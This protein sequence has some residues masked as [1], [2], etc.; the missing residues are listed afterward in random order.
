MAVFP[1]ELFEAI[2]DAVEDDKTLHACALVARSFTYPAQRNHFRALTLYSHLSRRS[3]ERRQYQT[4]TSAGELFQQPAS[5]HLALHVRELTVQLPFHPDETNAI[6]VVLDSTKN[7]VRLVA[8]AGSMRW[9]ALPAPARDALLCAIRRPTLQRLH[10]LSMTRIPSGVIAEAL[11]VPVVS[12]YSI[13]MD[14]AEEQADYDAAHAIQTSPTPRLRHLILRDSS[15]RGINRMF[16]ILEFLLHSRP[17][18]PSY[19]EGIRRIELRLDARH[20]GRDEQLLEVCASHLE[21]LL[22]D[23]EPLS[24]PITLPTL[25]KLTHISLKIVFAAHGALPPFLPA[26]ISRIVAATPALETLNLRFV[27]FSSRTTME[28]V[29]GANRLRLLPE[30][31]APGFSARALLPRLRR[32]ECTLVQNNIYTSAIRAVAVPKF[33]KAT[34]ELFPGPKVA[35]MLFHVLE[36]PPGRYIDR[37]P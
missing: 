6:R 28:S 30:F 36:D 9:T 7:V 2:L 15:P 35:G 19:T 11:A 33:V 5:A 21:S 16:R 8:S 25:P 20:L 14:T 27:A 22:L 18:R 34:E 29:N 26:N 32:V 37:L 31:A 17:R 3:T 13:V 1:Q 10:L 4:L 12:F 23:P 24:R